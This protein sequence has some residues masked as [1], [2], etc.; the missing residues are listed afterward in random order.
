MPAAGASQQKLD[1]QVFWLK[2]RDDP[3]RPSRLVAV[4]RFDRGP[5]RLQRRARDGFAPSSLFSP[6]A[7]NSERRHL[8]RKVIR[9]GGRAL[10]RMAPRAAGSRR[11][12]RIKMLG[13]R[14]RWGSARFKPARG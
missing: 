8:S 9:A 3:G 11:R 14:D 6:C 10:S 13:D 12:G 7:R 2:A 1:G 4:A 5:G